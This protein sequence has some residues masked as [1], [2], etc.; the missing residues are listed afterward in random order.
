MKNPNLFATVTRSITLNAGQAWVWRALTESE[1]LG[2]WLDA[3]VSCVPEI[4]GAIDI[5]WSD[6]S[7]VGGEIV[8]LDAPHHLIMHWWDAGK[9]AREDD[10]GMI[11][12]LLEMLDTGYDISQVNDEWMA[13]IHAGWDMFLASMQ[14]MAREQGAVDPLPDHVKSQSS[15]GLRIADP[16]QP[17]KGHNVSTTN[18][19]ECGVHGD[20]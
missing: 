11:T 6:G 13:E 1:F 19:Q 14:S 5:L 7:H 9:L 3:K 10:P 16:R 20:T 18:Y 8:L 17:Q 4:G 15:P 2:Q 12:V